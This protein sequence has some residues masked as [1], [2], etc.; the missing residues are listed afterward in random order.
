M[1]YSK[2]PDYDG[3]KNDGKEIEPPGELWTHPFD[4]V[5]SEFYRIASLTRSGIGKRV[6]IK[7]GSGETVPFGSEEAINLFM[8]QL[9]SSLPLPL[10]N[11]M[12]ADLR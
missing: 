4:E 7:Q 8:E 9:G 10:S 12:P 6:L 1:E 11:D 5:Q 2:V 3:S